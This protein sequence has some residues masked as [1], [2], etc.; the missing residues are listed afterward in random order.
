MHIDGAGR[1][2]GVA[3]DQ[4]VALCCSQFVEVLLYGVFREAVADG[5]YFD[6]F[7]V[8]GQ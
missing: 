7:G 1:D 6:Q 4:R 8:D 3:D 2:V 5:K